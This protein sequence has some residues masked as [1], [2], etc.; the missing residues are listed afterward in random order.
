M[1]E[2]KAKCASLSRLMGAISL[3]LLVSMISGCGTVITLKEDATF[4][5][6]GILIYS[7][8]VR[9]IENMAHTLLD[10]PFSL[11]LDTLVL[12]YTIP[13]SI[14]NY[15]HPILKDGKAQDVSECL[16]QGYKRGA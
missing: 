8:T 5:C 6:R 12:P 11:M 1:N 10:I 13:R 2:V 4:D 16:A 15:Y 9:S 14:W 3:V 7:G